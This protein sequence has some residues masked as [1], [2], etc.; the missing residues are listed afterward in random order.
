MTDA[1]IAVNLGISRRTATTHMHN[2]LSKR[3]LRSRLELM[4]AD[5][6]V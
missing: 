4:G 1:Q 6:A 2:I 3:G 5:P